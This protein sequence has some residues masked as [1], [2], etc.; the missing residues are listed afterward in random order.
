MRSLVLWLTSDCNLQCRYCYAANVAP[1]YMTWDTAK[2]ALETL[3]GSAYKLQL[4]GGEPL[5]NLPLVESVL[6]EASRC[7]ECWGISIQTNATLITEKTAALF[8]EYNVAVGV[9][10]DG[11]PEINELQRGQ[12][13][14]AIRGIR[15]LAEYGICA[16]ITCVVTAR[17][18]AALKELADLALYLGNIRGIGLDLLRRAGRATGGDT[19]ETRRCTPEALLCGLDALCSRLDQLNA[20]LPSQRQIV[21]REAVKAEVQLRGQDCCKEYC[22]AAQGNSFVVLPNGDCYPCGSLT[23]DPRYDMGNVHS[24]VRPRHIGC[25]APEECRHCSYAAVCTGGCPA[26]GLLQGGFDP[27]DCVIKKYM[28][29]RIESRKNQGVL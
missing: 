25:S 9:S 14:S 20:L 28:F 1:S 6:R 13:S 27:L 23:G 3:G 18:A 2:R 21:L 12:T 26:R 29:H 22:Y 17:N 4:A 11:M 5:L 19:P 7:P 15:C 16:N 10:L 8:R 24:Q